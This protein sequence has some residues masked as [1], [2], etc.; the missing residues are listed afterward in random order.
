MGVFGNGFF[1]SSSSLDWNFFGGNFERV[2]IN[3]SQR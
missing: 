1:A 3:E 2:M